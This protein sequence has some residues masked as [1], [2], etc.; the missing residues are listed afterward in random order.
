M[1]SSTKQPPLC[2]LFMFLSYHVWY[3]ICLTQ[4]HYVIVSTSSAS[5]PP[6]SK[7]INTSEVLMWCCS[8]LPPLGARGIAPSFV[9]CSLTTAYNTVFIQY[10][11]TINTI[12]M[13]AEE[14]IHILTNE[15]LKTE[16][17]AIHNLCHNSSAH[18]NDAALF[19]LC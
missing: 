13:L 10:I 16:V 11:R 18:L 9:G 7:C 19:K 2:I 12:S 15:R 3:I 8:L 5:C 17:A 1:S 6:H 14:T 4:L